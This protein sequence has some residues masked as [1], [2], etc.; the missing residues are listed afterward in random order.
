MPSHLSVMFRKHEYFVMKI[1]TG[2]HFLL[3]ISVFQRCQSYS[4]CYDFEVERIW[5]CFLPKKRGLSRRVFVSDYQIF[6]SSV[7]DD[8]W[9]SLLL[10]LTIRY[11]KRF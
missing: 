2:F 11:L 5:F 10:R 6:W 7:G 4:R 3:L 1:I 9:S 8:G